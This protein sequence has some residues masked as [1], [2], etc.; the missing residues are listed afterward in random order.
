[1]ASKNMDKLSQKIPPKEE[2]VVN[3]LSHDLVGSKIKDK[4]VY[5]IIET[6]ED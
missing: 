6:L 4:Q 1:M 5:K 2:L 3:S